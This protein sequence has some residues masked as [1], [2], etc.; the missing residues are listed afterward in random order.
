MTLIAPLNTL[1]VAFGLPV[2]LE[3]AQ[4]TQERSAEYQY[5]ELNGSLWR[6]GMW[7]LSQRRTPDTSGLCYFYFRFFSVL[8]SLDAAGSVK[9]L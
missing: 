5:S 6:L 1:V 3:A 4:E 9:S 7:W 2:C 8:K